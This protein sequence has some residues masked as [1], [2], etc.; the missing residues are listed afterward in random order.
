MQKEQHKMFQMLYFKLC[1]LINDVEGRIEQWSW[2]KY[3]Q[4]RQKEAF[5][6]PMQ[7]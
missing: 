5:C 2:V 4:A 7:N 1:T 3:I 6:P